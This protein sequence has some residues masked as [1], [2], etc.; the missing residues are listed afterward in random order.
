MAIIATDGVEESELLEPLKALE[1]AGALCQLIAPER[2]QI[3]TW[4]SGDWSKVIPVA[5]CF[6]DTHPDGY[7]A[8]LIPGGTLNCDTLRTE[9]QAID[10]VKHFLE[11]GKPVFAI[12]HGPQLLIEAKE[13]SGRAMTSVSA[14]Q[15]DLVNAG[16]KWR[17]A[18]V[19]E[20]RGLVTSRTPLDLPAFIR[21]MLQVLAREPLGAPFERSTL[22]HP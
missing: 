20:E 15:T 18:E 13:V 19:V 2:G 12:C 3:K 1:E 22:A 14:I 7:D 11:S 17:N 8:L 9:R 21:T 10:F 4:S 6:D 16:A 5:L